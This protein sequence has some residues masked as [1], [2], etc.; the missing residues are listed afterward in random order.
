MKRMIISEE[1]KNRI[2]GMHQ[3]A[4]KRHYLGEQSVSS[5]NANSQAMDN[6]KEL[7][8]QYL[9]KI[10]TFIPFDVKQLNGMVATL[11]SGTKEGGNITNLDVVQQ[12]FKNKGQEFIKKIN[13]KGYDEAINSQFTNYTSL[14]G[15]PNCNGC[16]KS[17]V[18]QM[19]LDDIIK[20]KN[21][22]IFISQQ[23]SGE[24]ATLP[25]WVQSPKAKSAIDIYAK[26]LGIS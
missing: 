21:G 9:Q 19:M 6:K 10:N 8:N 7:Y 14:I 20:L 18:Y 3:D 12:F 26:D 15:N 4:T 1:E 25:T 13:P 17:S 22:L 23:K 11:K 5:A 16:S 2:L 24:L